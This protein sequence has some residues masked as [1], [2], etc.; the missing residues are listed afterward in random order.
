MPEF[1]CSGLMTQEDLLC[2]GCRKTDEPRGCIWIGDLGGHIQVDWNDL[3][4]NWT[5]SGTTAP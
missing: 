4:F 3:H 2:D 5:R 1:A